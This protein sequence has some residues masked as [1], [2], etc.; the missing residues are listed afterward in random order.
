MSAE[1]ATPDVAE[2]PKADYHRRAAADPAGG[3]TPLEALRFDA[4][5]EAY[6]HDD[7]LTFYVGL[8]RAC[9]FTAFLS[10]TAAF[11]GYSWV[12]MIAVVATGL[13]MVLKFP[14]RIR[15]HSDLKRRAFQ[16]CERA[17]A[18]NAN[19]DD[20]RRELQTGYADEPAIMHAVNALAHNRAAASI[21]RVRQNHIPMRWFETALRHIWPFASADF[22][23][24]YL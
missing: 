21:G 13:D 4:M 19:I 24:R 10:A 22:A 5:R 14:E 6:Y 8:H 20:L 16:V 9:I 3:M 17:D 18:S 1:Y 12:A 11:G 7:R 2:T 15:E 23:S